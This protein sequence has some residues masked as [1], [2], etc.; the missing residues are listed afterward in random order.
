MHRLNN[1]QNRRRGQREG[2]EGCGGTERLETGK[3]WENKSEQ[4]HNGRSKQ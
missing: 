4:I 2:R 1:R 3:E